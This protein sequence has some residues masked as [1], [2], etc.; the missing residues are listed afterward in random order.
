MNI[1]W[2]YLV[3]AGVL[4]WGWPIG[5]KLGWTSNGIRPWPVALAVLCVIGSGA[6]LF[7]AQRTI[8]MGTAYA[9]WTGIG[10]A[11]TFVLGILFLGEPAHLQRWIFVGLIIAG[12][13][14][15]KMSSG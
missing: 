1:A 11:G 9:V 4:E 6:F 5:V 13:V 12:I 2:I 15:L 14:G 8:P 3:T 10:A 7:L